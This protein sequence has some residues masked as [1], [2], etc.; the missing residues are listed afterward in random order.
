MKIYFKSKKGY[1]TKVAV[2]FTIMYLIPA[3]ISWWH[4]IFM[5]LSISFL[6]VFIMDCM[7]LII[8]K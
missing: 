2:I 8:E 4:P 7:E 3:I 5:T 1:K 6:I